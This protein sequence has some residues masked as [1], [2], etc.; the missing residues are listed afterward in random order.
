MQ[1]RMQDKAGGAMIFSD[2]CRAFYDDGGTGLLGIKT[3]RGVAEFLLSD[4]LG[5]EYSAQHIYDSSLYGK[6]FNDS[7]HKVSKVIWKDVDSSLNEEDYAKL[8]SAKL[9][10]EMLL[11][12]AKRLGI[13]VNSGETINSEIFSKA[14][15]AQIRRFA[16]MLGVAENVIPE[17]YQEMT[18]PKEFAKYIY[19][20][21]EYFSKIKSFLSPNR[22]TLFRDIYVCNSVGSEP[23]PYVQPSEYDSAEEIAIDDVTADKLLEV[24]HHILIIGPGGI[25]K[26]MMMRHLFLDTLDNTSTKEKLPIFV[27]LREFGEG[28]RELLDLIVASARRFDLSLEQTKIYQLLED[29]RCIVFFDGMDEIESEYYDDYLR[30]IDMLSG[31]FPNCQLI[32]STRGIGRFVNLRFTPLWIKFF[33][34]AQIKQFAMKMDSYFNNSEIKWGFIEKVINGKVSSN[35]KI[36]MH[37]PLFLAITM[38]VFAKNKTLPYRKIELYK[39]MLDMLLKKHDIEEK[40]GFKRKFRSVDNIQDFERVLSEFSARLFMVEEDVFTYETCNKLFMQLESAKN[41]E[42]KKMNAD[43]FL[44]DLCNNAIILLVDEKHYAFIH[45]TIQGYLFAKYFSNVDD[46]KL[47]ELFRWASKSNGGLSVNVELAM[48]LLNETN[49]SRFAEHFIMPVLRR[50]FESNSG[51]QYLEFL[52]EFF[53]FIQYVI[54]YPA[55]QDEYLSDP[56]NQRDIEVMCSNIVDCAEL[57]LQEFIT[58]KLYGKCNINLWYSDHELECDDDTGKLILL[59]KLNKSDF[60]YSITMLNDLIFYGKEKKKIPE[61]RVVIKDEKAYEKT[62]HDNISWREYV[63]DHDG[64]PKIY[65]KAYRIEVSSIIS[66]P[67]KYQSLINAVSDDSNEMY[68]MYRRMMDYYENHK[69]QESNK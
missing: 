66:N 51:N 36:L 45:K 34:A 46:N 17:T 8:L 60:E 47:D 18:K 57:P 61:F 27:T 49:P 33:S 38:A 15:S 22:M 48:E 14:V 50:V 31:L 16:Q 2:L 7:L 56:C 12:I 41:L 6:W 63:R 42:S 35:T 30:Q 37:N 62:I 69:K 4:A 52:K 21:K 19:R 13:E 53:Q 9:N 40:I 1:D 29:N 10:P 67:G 25:G 24:S 39:D 65:G 5:E 28:K 23:W 3:K 55:E 11:V 32:I 20:S 64:K 26:T 44:F 54:M 58:K 59:K 68:H 43:N